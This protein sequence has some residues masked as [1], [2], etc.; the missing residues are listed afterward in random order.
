MMRFSYKEG[1]SLEIKNS[2]DYLTEDFVTHRI[3]VRTSLDD[4]INRCPECK[5][6]YQDLFKNKRSTS[7]S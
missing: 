7:N 6:R 5:Q 1:S 3:N 4:L 2:L